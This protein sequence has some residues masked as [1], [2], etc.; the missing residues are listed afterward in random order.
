[1]TD[2]FSDDTLEHRCSAGH[3]WR[4][5]TNGQV[6][7]SWGLGGTYVDAGDP[8]LCPEPA[9]DENGLY[10]CG[11][12]GERHSP[13]DGLAGLSFTPWE[14]AN[15]QRQECGVPVPACRQPAVWTRRW[16]DHYLPWPHG[17]GQLYSLW[18]ITHCRDGQRLVAY[19]GNDA[20]HAQVVDV[21]SGEP[22]RIPFA[23]PDSIT[24]ETRKAGVPDLPARLRTIWP[25]H[26]RAGETGGLST[27][28]LLANINADYVALCELHSHGLIQ[29][30]DHEGQ[31]T[32]AILSAS[33]IPA[34]VEREI[35]RRLHDGRW[36]ATDQAAV[37]AAHAE[38]VQRLR[39]ERPAP[40][41]SGG[42]LR[43]GF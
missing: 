15:G 19:V 40:A 21:Q 25:R 37:I 11:T 6:T 43:L 18:R 7:P 35:R 32:R 3:Y 13:G 42:Q 28:W 33:G 17:P 4:E 10:R 23:D 2:M 5:H 16:G 9:T 12:C 39:A 24:A 27:S 38:T 1:M 8:S 36:N 20:Q 26:T 14:F 22:L 30:S 34:G 29:L 41:G 31:F